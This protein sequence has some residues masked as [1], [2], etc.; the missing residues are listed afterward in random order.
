MNCIY[1]FIS[2]FLFSATNDLIVVAKCVGDGVMFDDVMCTSNTDIIVDIVAYYGE[3]RGAT[4]CITAIQHPFNPHCTELIDLAKHE[5]YFKEIERK[6][7]HKR[8]CENL[9]VRSSGDTDCTWTRWGTEYVVI[10][11]TCSGSE[12]E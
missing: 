5:Q 11:Y 8:Q 4:S 12:S 1:K 9:P 7:L 2:R 6:C 3:P 10:K